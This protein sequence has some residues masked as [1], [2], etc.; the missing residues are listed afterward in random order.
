MSAAPADVDLDDADGLLEADTDG[1]LRASAMAGAQV[2]ATAAAVDEG[3]LESV[4]GGQRPRTVIWLAGRG[5]AEAAGSLLISALAGRAGE[6]LVTATEAP[7]WIGPLDVLIVAGDDPGD[8]AVVSAAATAVRRGARVVVAAPYLG[9]LRDATAG[10]AAVLEPRLGVPDEFGL[11][12]YLAAGLAT[13][14]A[15]DPSTPSAGLAALADGLDAEALRNSAAREVF[16]NPAK[17]L[18]ERMAGR[19]VVLTG[20]CPATL[21]LARHASSVLVRVAGQPVAAVGLGDVVV[22]LRRGILAGRTD[23]VDALFHD[24]EIDGPLPGRPRVVALSL[25]DERQVLVARTAGLDDVHLVGAEDVGEAGSA[26]P[27]AV[28]A[29][30]QLATLAVRLEMAAVYRKLAGG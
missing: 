2:R 3:A 20:D 18:A 22:A 13:M 14:A 11:C 19:Q 21:A 4:A 8:P 16:T 17:A 5:P 12:R 6:P 10:R 27:A 15:V 23:P 26:P 25:A 30:E 1:L 29:E 24:E 7:P 28:R 9:P